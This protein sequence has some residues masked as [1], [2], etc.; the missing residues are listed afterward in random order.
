MP[1]GMDVIP[2]TAWN[3]PFFHTSPSLL[4]ELCKL[5]LIKDLLQFYLPLRIHLLSS[6]YTI[7]LEH[8][9]GSTLRQAGRLDHHP[10]IPR[11][12]GIVGSQSS[13]RNVHLPMRRLNLAMMVY[14]K[15]APKATIRIV[16]PTLAVLPTIPVWALEKKK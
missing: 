14:P 8:T 16:I 6:S 15:L 13:R 3:K 10:P 7:R 4:P 9:T 5:L 2:F 11:I 12:L 1:R